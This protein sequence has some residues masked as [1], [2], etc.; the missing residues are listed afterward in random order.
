MKGCKMSFAE[1]QPTFPIF[2]GSHDDDECPICGAQIVALGFDSG[3]C[4]SCAKR[5]IITLREKIAA[6]QNEQRTGGQLCLDCG[7]SA[8]IKQVAGCLDH[9]VVYR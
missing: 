7:H 3:I 8:E 4:P 6:Q 9:P 2:T 1:L 5:E